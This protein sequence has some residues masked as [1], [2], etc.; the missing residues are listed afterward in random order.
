LS[1]VDVWRADARPEFTDRTTRDTFGPLE[2]RVYICGASGLGS[3]GTIK[4]RC[5]VAQDL[6][7]TGWGED[8]PGIN[9]TVAEALGNAGINIEG[10]FGSG[11]LGEIHILVGDADAARRALEGTGYRVEERDALVIQLED[12]PGAWGA[13]ARRLADAGVNIDFNYLATGTR[14]VVG[15]DD[16]EKARSAT[17]G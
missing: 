5:A 8:R 16:I 4:R 12:S 6:T 1:T 14:M 13:V 15:P 3:P 10:T 17:G 9:A 2:R 7:V 11:R